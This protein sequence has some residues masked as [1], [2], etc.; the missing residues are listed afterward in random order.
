M[1][2]ACS[3][4]LSASLLSPSY[5]Q[6]PAHSTKETNDKQ[7]VQQPETVSLKQPLAFGLEDGTKITAPS[8][9]R[10]C[11]RQTTL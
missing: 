7:A 3:C 5:S 8:R 10:F 4:V 2:V 9:R 1:R 11:G 6:S